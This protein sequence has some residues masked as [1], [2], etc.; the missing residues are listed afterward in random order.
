MFAFVSLSVGVFGLVAEPD[1]DHQATGNKAISL[2]DS[3]DLQKCFTKTVY[4]HRQT[5]V[6]LLSTCAYMLSF[7]FVM[8]Q[9]LDILS[10]QYSFLR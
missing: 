5:K 4:K 1:F 6:D 8:H 10:T 7:C 3:H 9:V 2:K